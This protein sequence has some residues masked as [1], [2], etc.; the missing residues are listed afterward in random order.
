MGPLTS[1]SLW[2]Q[3]EKISAKHVAQCMAWSECSVDVRVGAFDYEP[4]PVAR[5]LQGFL[6]SWVHGPGPLGESW[7][8]LGGPGISHVKAGGLCPQSVSSPSLALWDLHTW[9]QE[10]AV[11]AG[12][13]KLGRPA[14]WASGRG[15]SGLLRIVPNHGSCLPEGSPAVCHPC[16]GPRHLQ[17]GFLC[18]L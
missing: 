9:G 15:A 8:R 4:S 12:V 2:V 1:T 10:M 6:G 3:W 5:T 18:F 14:C 16:L 13:W 7:S 17:M 11:W